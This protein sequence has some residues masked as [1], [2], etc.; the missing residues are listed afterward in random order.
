MGTPELLAIK[1][2]ALDCFGSQSQLDMT[3]F[4]Q[5][6]AVEYRRYVHHRVVADFP[7]Q[8]TCAE[9]SAIARRVEFAEQTECG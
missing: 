8:S 3:V 7:A 2:C 6:A 1:A 4:G 9:L 5:L